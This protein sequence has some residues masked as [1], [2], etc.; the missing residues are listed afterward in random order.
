LNLKTILIVSDLKVTEGDKLEI[1]IS[2]FEGKVCKRCW[3]LFEEL[4]SDELCERC[5]KIIKERE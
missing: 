5:S 1:K 2:K 4:D 3:A